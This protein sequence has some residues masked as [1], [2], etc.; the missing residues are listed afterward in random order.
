[1]IGLSRNTG[2]SLGPW[3]IEGDQ[4]LVDGADEVD[5][6]DLANRIVEELRSVVGTMDHRRRPRDGEA[7]VVDGADEVDRADLAMAML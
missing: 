7:G 4:D 3:T 6:A 5:R 2:R 1:M